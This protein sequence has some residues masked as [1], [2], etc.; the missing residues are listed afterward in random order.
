MKVLHLL[1]TS[2]F[3][4]AENVACQ[5]SALLKDQI[6]FIYCSLDGEIRNVLRDRRIEFA[7]IKKMSITE[8]KRVIQEYKPDII[9]AHD[10]YASFYA[11]L[12]CGRIPL[13]SHIHNNAFDSRSLSLKSLAF[14]YAAQK[15]KH[16]FWVS[17]TA[18]SGYFFHSLVASKSSIL[19]N[20]INMN[21]LQK[22]KNEDVNEYDYDIV[23]L[24]RLTYQKNP[25]RLI[26]IFANLKEVAP[27]FKACIIGDGPLKNVVE[28]LIEENKLQE[29]VF[30]LGYKKNP[31]KIL[32][33]SKAMLLV[34]R[35]E[36][37]PMCVLEAL[38]LGVPVIT[39]PTDGVRSIVS[40]GINGFI[41]DEDL[42]IVDELNKIINDSQYHSSLSK[43]AVEL[44]EN[45]NNLD[46]Y[47]AEIYSV[48]NQSLR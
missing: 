21:D 27:T 34:S 46:A 28:Q 32:H 38:A 39:T 35:W 12:S 30:L 45:H 43:K 15:A 10:M 22:K 26:K 3:S 13:V 25:E 8:L 19:L 47:R 29:N 37:L 20:R 9:H 6:D 14:F 16:I 5:I 17:S 44:S 4:G 42:L 48:Y 1:N 18:F 33:D 40:N 11:S 41:C 24:G 7:P 31:L 36:G 2:K 23:F